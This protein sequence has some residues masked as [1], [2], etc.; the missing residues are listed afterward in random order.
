MLRVKEAA[1]AWLAAQPQP[2]FSKGI[3]KL[4]QRWKKCFE[5]QGDYVEKWCY[6][7]FYNFIEIKFVSVVRIIIDSHTLY[8]V[9]ITVDVPSNIFEPSATFS[10][11]ALSPRHQ[12]TNKWQRISMR[13]ISFG[14]KNR[15]TGRIYRASRWRNVP[16]FGRMFLTLKY[17]DITQNTYI[18]RWTVTEIMAREVWKYD[19]CYTLIDYQIHIKTARNI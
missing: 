1:H 16:D 5:K 12:H 11:T 15:I 13:E 8:A 14:N 18:R 10:D 4:V 3:K 2:F 7:K 19:S 6:H 17:T 9:I